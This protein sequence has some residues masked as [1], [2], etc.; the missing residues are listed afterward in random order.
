MSPDSLNLDGNP[1]EIHPGESLLALTRRC[2]TEVPSLCYDERLKGYGSCRMCLVKVNGRLAASC[3]LKAEASQTIVT[4]DPD[5]QR[6]RKGL[7]ELTMSLLPD[8]PCEACRVRGGC[9]MHAVAKQVGAKPGRF[10]GTAGGAKKEDVNPFLGRN[11][12]LCINCYRCVRICDEIEGDNAIT[13][14]GRGF[15][16][17]IATFMD[18]GLED[19]S[20]EFCGQCI[21]TCPTGAL[22]D[23]KLAKRIPLD[24]LPAEIKRVDTT[25]PYC[26]TGCG[27]TLNTARGKL[28]GVTPQMHAGA[29]EGAL[30]VKGQFGVDFI[31]SPE[32]L[33]HPLIR[34]PDGSFKKSSWD[35]AVNLISEKLHATI[36]QHG[37]D[38]FAG[39][40]SSRTTSESNYLFMKFV[41]GGVGTD[42]LDN[43][44]RT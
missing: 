40:A 24:V 44:Q 2:G 42:N 19:S 4:D 35:E 41:R 5:L 33:T 18:R 1:I 39:W 27:I 37:P 32:R 25:C 10:A 6:L 36:D 20:C 17:T 23:A 7:G 38:S 21:H 30:C 3:T 43:C 26:G 28:L 22:F 12:D 34:Q 9:E 31:E 15:A 11:Y 16:S 8:G 13:A 14:K 29:S